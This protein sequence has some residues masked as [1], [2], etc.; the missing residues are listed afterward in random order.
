MIGR[1]VVESVVDDQGPACGA[2]VVLPE[3]RRKFVQVVQPRSLVVP[4]KVFLV[5]LGRLR[6]R[7]SSVY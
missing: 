1:R 4:A 2:L 3:P 5:Q 7:E 6:L